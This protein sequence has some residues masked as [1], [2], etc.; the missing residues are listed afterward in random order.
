MMECETLED[1]MVVLEEG[2][3]NRQVGAHSV[4]DHSSRSHTMLTV[5]LESEMVCVASNSFFDVMHD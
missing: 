2:L 1:L 4:N 3:R 5:Y